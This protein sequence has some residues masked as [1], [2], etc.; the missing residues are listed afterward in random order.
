MMMRDRSGLEVHDIKRVPSTTA[1]TRPLSSPLKE[2]CI[3]ATWPRIT[4]LEPGARSFLA[5]LTMRVMSLATLPKIGLARRRR[6]NY[7]CTL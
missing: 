1:N 4:T 3:V 6:F 7:C 5:S 2:D